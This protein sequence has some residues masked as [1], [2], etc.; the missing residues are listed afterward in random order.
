MGIHPVGQLTP[1][2]AEMEGVGTVWAGAGTT[3]PSAVQVRLIQDLRPTILAAMPSYALHLANVA[4]LEG[5]DLASG[6]VKKLLMSAE[7]LTPAK[8]EKR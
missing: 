5:I 2:S 4:R 6:S 1:R 8:R 7:P 3:T